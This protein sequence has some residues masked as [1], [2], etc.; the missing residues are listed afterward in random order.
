MNALESLRFFVPEAVLLAGGFLALF[1]D[2]FLRN[3]KWI[4]GFA[5]AVL[6]VTAC[7]CVWPD[8]NSILFSGFFA[9]DRFTYFFRFLAL[10]V[11]AV[12]ILLSLASPETSGKNEGEYYVLFLFM[13]FALILAAAAVNL[14]AIYMAIEFVSI[15]SYLLTGFVKKNPEAKEAAVKYLLF[16]SVC[17]GIMLFGMSLLYGASG[18]LDIA[19]IGA[20]LGSPA[21]TGLALT[22][23]LLMLAGI[24]FKI[25]M[26]PFH[27]WAPDVYQA[28]PTPVTAFLTVAPKAVGFA[29]LI[30]LLSAS[31]PALAWKWQAVIM[32][33]SML[34]MTV[35]NLTAISQ[36]NIKRFL[37]YS[38]IA[39][40]GYILM[41][42]TVLNVTGLSAVLIYFAVYAFTNL[43]A[44]TVVSMVSNQ[45]GNDDLSSY[46]GLARRSPVPAACMTVFLLSLAGLPPL[47]GFVGKLFVFSAAIEA[48]YV[49]LAT[50]AA[51]NSA[52]AAYYYFKIVRLMYLT[53]PIEKTPVASPWPIRLALAFT[54]AGTLGLGLFP[55]P[56]IG[57]VRLVLGQ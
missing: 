57:F 1:L 15:L 56:L 30:R 9:L 16:G 8:K 3:K 6:V 37:A 42:V 29:V 51:L 17:S 44:F 11:V 45:C 36:V 24:G 5:L 13:A 41:G 20:R 21:W 38:S 43:G 25:S 7:L 14:L 32:G 23:L 55:A 2:F 33:L 19:A 54:L 27:L 26:A 49:L 39:Q 10:S 47:A 12:T 35:G 22:G 46:A 18:S 48:H 40:A 53:G 50:V 31:F 28:A 4:G 52:A 34:T